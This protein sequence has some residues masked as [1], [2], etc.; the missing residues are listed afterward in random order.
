M[1][2]KIAIDT[3]EQKMIISM[4]TVIVLDARLWHQAND[5][6]HTVI[7]SVPWSLTPDPETKQVLTVIMIDTKQ[8]L[9]SFVNAYRDCA[10]RLTLVPRVL[11][12]SDDFAERNLRDDFF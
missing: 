2:T 4:L 3:F 10:W 6:V 11:R 12:C 1:L 5:C 7:K 8:V 9:V